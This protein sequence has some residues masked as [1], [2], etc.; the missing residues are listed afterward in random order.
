M[1]FGDVS[2]MNTESK[3]RPSDSEYEGFELK[4]NVNEMNSPVMG[5]ELVV[6]IHNQQ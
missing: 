2:E 1:P 5:E 3:E 6:I 4:K